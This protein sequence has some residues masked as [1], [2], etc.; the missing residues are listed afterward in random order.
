MLRAKVDRLEIRIK[1]ERN[2][3]EEQLRQKEDDITAVESELTECKKEISG[4]KKTI[5]SLRNYIDKLFE[6]GAY[7]AKK[8][9]MDF[10]NVVNRR[11]DGYSLKHIFGDNERER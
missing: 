1:S 9:R 5:D 6:I 4:L 3:Y 7:M 10:E 2:E 11:L 8:F